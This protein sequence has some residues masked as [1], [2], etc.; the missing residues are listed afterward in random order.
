MIRTLAFLAVFVSAAVLMVAIVSTVDPISA[1]DSA[2]SKSVLVLDCGTP[3]DPN[4]ATP[5]AGNG[6]VPCVEVTPEAT[7]PSE[8]P[9]ILELPD[10]GTG[11]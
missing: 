11:R 6:P 9:E 7:I 5:D 10:T 3:D 8:L 1:A 4:V 2:P